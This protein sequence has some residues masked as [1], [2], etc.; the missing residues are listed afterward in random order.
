MTKINL[1]AQDSFEYEFEDGLLLVNGEEVSPAML[2]HTLE[3][4]LRQM[5]RDAGAGEKEDDKRNAAAH[6]KIAALIA[7]TLR[8]GTGGGKRMD[9]IE[10]RAR[11]I[12]LRKVEAAVFAK[13]LGWTRK[14]MQD[15][16]EALYKRDADI[17]RAEAEIE[18]AATPES[19]DDILADLG[20]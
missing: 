11:E 7:G 12:A 20:L 9:P 8:A 2:I 15:H 17:L 19:S 16:A 6:K 3:F 1:W 10:R 14:A 13:K 5:I 4:G 18:L